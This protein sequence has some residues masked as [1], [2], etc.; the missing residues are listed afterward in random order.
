[1]TFSAILCRSS[2]QES[3]SAGRA[4]RRPVLWLSILLLALSAVSVASAAEDVA[5][6]RSGVVEV[7]PPTAVGTR[8]QGLRTGD[9]NVTENAQQQ[10]ETAIAADP[11]HPGNLVAGCNDYRNGDSD[12]GVAYSFDGGE[13]WTA[14]TLAA[15]DPSLGKYDAQGDPAI[16]AYRDGVFYYAFIDF[17]RSDDRNRL[18]VARS[19]DGGVTWPQLGVI[20]DHS[21][22]GSEDFE[23]KEYIAVDNTGGPHDGN[24]YVTWTRFPVSGD[25]EIFFARS[26]DGGA[27]FSTPVVISDEPGVQGSVPVVGAGGEIF[28]AWKNGA[29][30]VVDRST[31]GGLTWGTDVVI[32]NIDPIPSPLPGAGF[33][34]NSFPTL[35]TF[36]PPGAPQPHVYAAWADES[37]GGAG[38]DILFSR[39]LD[40]AATWSPAI[41]V[42]DDDNAAF[43]WFPWM[44]VDPAGNID[45]VFFDRRHSPNSSRYH[46]YHARSRDGGLSFETNRRLSDEESDAANGGFGGGFIGD[47]NGL[48]S[49]SLGVRAYWTDTRDSNG[50]AEG[51]TDVDVSTAV[52]SGG[53]GWTAAAIQSSPNPFRSSTEIRFALPRAGAATVAIYD[54]SGRRLWEASPSAW[55]QGEHAVLWDGR[56]ASGTL[57]PSGVYL[58]RFEGEGIRLERK[59]TLTR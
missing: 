44:A 56:S 34:V 1:M 15:L 46:T 48:V 47:Y 11:S 8:T 2:L 50:N 14:S 40:G 53:D 12:V 4:A 9:V 26:T 10:N 20:I 38:P 51:Y 31:D 39:S 49:T 23:D 18:A 32:A 52:A 30:I 21:G 7:G 25:V 35:A 37:A 17:S 55:S 5:P 57:L 27:S 3:P 45:V 29:L 28:V 33:R 59:L 43:Q 54:V 41:R 16:A 6:R 22:T 13:S 19:V 58:C 24:V 36:Q 42:S